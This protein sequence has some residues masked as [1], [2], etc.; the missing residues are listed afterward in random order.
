MLKTRWRTHSGAAKKWNAKAE[1]EKLEQKIASTN[2]LINIKADPDVE[3]LEK[4]DT[5]MDLKDKLDENDS[6][7]AVRK[8]KAKVLLEGEK[9][10]KYFCSL[11]K[12]VEKHTGITEL[13]IEH[14]QENGPP[15]IESIRDQAEIEK[16]S[17]ISTAIF[18]PKESPQL[19]LPGL[20][21]SWEIH[22]LLRS[23]AKSSG[24]TLN[25]KFQKQKSAGIWE[26]LIVD[27]LHY[28][29]PF[30]R[31]SWASLQID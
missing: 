14:E 9:P 10:T 6:K 26:A 1:R 19:Q 12:I 30:I 15:I 27:L 25:Y 21:T 28:L 22:P 17:V 18:I 4:F 2:R 20:K 16:K 11:Q 13:H 5:Y 24:K 7:D 8:H 29:I 31:S 3:L 23:S